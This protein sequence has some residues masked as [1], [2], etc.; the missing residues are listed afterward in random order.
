MASETLAA[1]PGVELSY[2][3]TGAP[4]TSSLYT[5]VIALHG[6]CFN[7]QIFERILPVAC[8]KGVRFVAPNRRTFPGST[9]LSPEELNLIMSGGPEEKKDAEIQAL[10]H[11][12]A[13]FIDNFIQKYNIPPISEDGR[14][15]GIVFLAWS[16][17]CTFAFATIA[18]SLTL[19]AE[20]RDRL[21][22][23]IR[24]L[25]LYDPA[26]SILGLPNPEQNWAP[27]I[28]TTIPQELRLIAFG[29]WVTGYFEHG[30]L[31]KRDLSSLS[32][33]IPSN[34]RVPT[35]Y[36]ISKD[37]LNEMG[38]FGLDAV[39]DLMLLINFVDQLKNAYRKTCYDA[40]IIKTF[41]AMKVTLLTSD[42]TPAF[43]P[44]GMWA[45]QDDEKENGGTRPVNYKIVSGINHFWHWEDPESAFDG[46]MALS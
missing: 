11:Q 43:G 31:S 19:P 27:L 33:V 2:I 4:S 12:I 28:D 7:N 40:E 45:M 14:S 10:G 42:T 9:A 38:S 8:K 41:P 35:I 26:P 1:G 16:L 21:A 24:S 23:R 34:N 32:W 44:A 46:F 13:L 15:G 36:N 20:V 30:D 37:K 18:S 17:G 3:D 39:P 22:S 6:M 25:I 5:T 29:Q